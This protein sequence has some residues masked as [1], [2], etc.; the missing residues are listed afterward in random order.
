MVTYD[1][2]IREKGWGRD[3]LS[4]RSAM[5][6]LQYPY[7]M[8]YVKAQEQFDEESFEKA[9]L[10]VIDKLDAAA[11]VGESPAGSPFDAKL[12]WYLLRLDT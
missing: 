12:A 10:H 4:I 1:A 3:P 8:H 7:C 9:G 11:L 6:A 5:E 2:G